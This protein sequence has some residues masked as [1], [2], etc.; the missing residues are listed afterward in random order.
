MPGEVVFLTEHDNLS[1]TSI[2]NHLLDAT[3][4]LR[5]NGP[6]DVIKLGLDEVFNAIKAIKPI[7]AEG[8][9]PIFTFP[10]LNQQQRALLNRLCQGLDAA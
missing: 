3:D 4:K 2:A 8:Q 7:L 9:G 5:Q 1:P 10:R 6:D